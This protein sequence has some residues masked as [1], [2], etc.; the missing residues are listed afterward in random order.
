MEAALARLETAARNARAGNSAQPDAALVNRHEAL[1][2][3][4]N[5]SLAELDAL[6]GVLGK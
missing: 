2:R 5:A 6:I 4:V 3:S 1:R